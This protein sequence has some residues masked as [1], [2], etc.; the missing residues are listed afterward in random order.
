M[1]EPN[2]CKSLRE[3]EILDAHFSVLADT[4]C[5]YVLYYFDDASEEVASLSDLAA[6]VEAN[7]DAA[8]DAS[9]DRVEI[10]LH[11]HALPQLADT[12]VLEYDERD[13]LVRYRGSSDIETLATLAAERER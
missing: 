5:R 8:V 4:E 3:S 9:R 7:V 1:S 2:T 6:F 13:G 10:R 11:H 12:G